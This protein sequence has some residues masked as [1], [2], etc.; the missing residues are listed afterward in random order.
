MDTTLDSL[1]EQQYEVTKGCIFNIQRFS[2]H[3]GPGI[4]TTVFFKGCPLRCWWC[5]NPESQVAVPEL[6]YSESKCTRCYRC[7]AACPNAATTIAPDGS[8]KI[9]R[10]LCKGCGKCVDA[11][12]SGARAIAGKLM[13]VDEVLQDIKSDE[14]FYRNSGG[15]VTASGGEPLTQPEFLS[16]LFQACQRLG[17]A[18]CLDTCGYVPWEK[19]D[20][21]LKYTD[22]VLYDIKHIDPSKHTDLTGVDNQLILKNA[23]RIANNGTPL[24]V[25]V[26]LIPGHND[27]TKD[28]EALG[29]YVAKL[30]NGRI[31]L[32]PYHEFGVGKYVKLG[33]QYQLE[34]LN[35]FTK[36]DLEAKVALLEQYGL[37]VHIS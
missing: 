25:R 10:N 13:T 29:A 24:I 6:L 12:L 27:S 32:L 19:L 30:G 2:I 33:M 11:C 23:E 8:I 31:D 7:V 9:D 16:E 1:R 22:L 21:V 36:E 5:S 4:R 37:E 15:G 14:L 35:S 34:G 20:M 28:L 17:Y 3:D 26:P 18:T